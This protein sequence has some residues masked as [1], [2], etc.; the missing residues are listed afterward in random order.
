MRSPF[1]GAPIVS[2]LPLP[3][4]F[5]IDGRTVKGLIPFPVK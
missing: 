1:V 3:R 4:A 5:S 2:C